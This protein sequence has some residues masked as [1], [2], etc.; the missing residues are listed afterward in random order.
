MESLLLLNNEIITLRGLEESDVDVI[1]KFWN[2]DEFMA[3]SGRIRTFSKTEIKNWIQRSW[4]L[5]QQRKEYIF[6][7]K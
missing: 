4:N 6:G 5:R 1:S 3:F 7:I 2:K